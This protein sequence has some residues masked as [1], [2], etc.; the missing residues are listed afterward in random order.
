MCTCMYI[1]V[2]TSELWSGPQETGFADLEFDATMSREGKKPR[3][4]E[5]KLWQGRQMETKPTTTWDPFAITVGR[6][7]RL[8]STS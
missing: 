1:D 6:L 4:T 7:T 8:G 3:L 2:H 5:E